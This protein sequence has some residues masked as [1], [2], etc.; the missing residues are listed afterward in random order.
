MCMTFSCKC[1]YTIKCTSSTFAIISSLD[2]LLLSVLFFLFSQRE[3]REQQLIHQQTEPALPPGWGQATHVQL[4]RRILAPA[5]SRSEL[6]PLA[7]GQPRPPQELQLLSD[8]FD[9]LPGD[10]WPSGAP[11]P[12]A[13]LALRTAHLQLGGSGLI[14]PAADLGVPSSKA[15]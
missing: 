7:S 10:P 3:H 6:N 8:R 9:G 4:R 5:E 11:A 1:T 15:L 14:I 2:L 12:A 13:G